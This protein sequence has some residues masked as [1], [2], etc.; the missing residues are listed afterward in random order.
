M[1]TTPASGSSESPFRTSTTTPECRNSSQIAF[2]RTLRSVVKRSKSSVERG[3]PRAATATA[4]VTA[5]WTPIL[6]SVATTRCRIT[7]ASRSYSANVV[8]RFD[9]RAG[10]LGQPFRGPTFEPPCTT[11][12]RARQA[13]APAL[14]ARSASFAGS[15]R[16]APHGAARP[17]SIARFQYNG[18]ARQGACNGGSGMR[19]TIVLLLALLAACAAETP[20]KKLFGELD[21]ATSWMATLQFAGEKWIANSVPD[22]FL[23]DC[24]ATAVPVLQDGI[25]SIDASRAPGD[26]RRELRL[27]LNRSIELAFS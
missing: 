7:S 17:L 21:S 24:V 5:K 3:A 8:G 19:R 18:P 2:C 27:Q 26:L 13:E 6:W 12:D 25:Q 10:S 4:P 16:S 1:R 11:R 23:R 14:H 22:S 9:A 20:Q 15:P